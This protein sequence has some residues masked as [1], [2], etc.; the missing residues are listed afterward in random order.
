MPAALLAEPRA[1]PVAPAQ[2]PLTDDALVVAA[3]AGDGPAFGTLVERYER[4]VYHLAYRTL[5][6]PEE[7]KDAAQ[8]AFFKAFRA[9]RTFRPGAKFSTWIL[10]IVYHACCDRLS[11]RKRLS[12]AEPPDWADPAAGPAQQAESADEARRLR[13]AI[14]ALPQKY[15]AVITL[16]H[17]QNRQYEEIA[18]VLDL[19]LG[20]VKTH[21]FRAKELLRRALDETNAAGSG[22]MTERP[23][24]ERR[25][26]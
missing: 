16:F 18:Q 3:L 24:A 26:S 6:D 14:D 2:V 8:E 17:L 20:T 25:M 13:A 19:P 4:A 7:A 9:L 22:Q 5:H 15:R 11:R 10:T 23:Q 21:L 12:T 1:D